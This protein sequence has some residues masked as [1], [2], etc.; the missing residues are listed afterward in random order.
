MSQ[1]E[2]VRNFGRLTKNKAAVQRADFS[3]NGAAPVISPPAERLLCT[4]TADPVLAH[5]CVLQLVHG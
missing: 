3:Q 4:V 5:T 1:I 2:S